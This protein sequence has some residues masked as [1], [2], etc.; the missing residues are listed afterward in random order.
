MTP[1]LPAICKAANAI[2]LSVYSRQLSVFIKIAFGSANELEYQLF[3][4][5]DLGF[6]TQPEHNQ[7]NTDVTEI[8]RMLTGLIRTVR[9]SENTR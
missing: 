6:L 1:S 5:H 8:K 4:A 7:L 9:T 2:R 3:L